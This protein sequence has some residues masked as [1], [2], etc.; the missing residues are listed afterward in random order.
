M[1]IAAT[2]PRV[3]SEYRKASIF[4][5]F[6]WRSLPVTPPATPQGHSSQGAFLSDIHFT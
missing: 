3:E 6:H 5:G 4:K 2:L 1:I